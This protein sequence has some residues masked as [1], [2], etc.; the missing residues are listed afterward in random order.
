MR[1][2]RPL[3]LC[4]SALSLRRQSV[5][6]PYS[7]RSFHQQPNGPLVAFVVAA[8]LPRKSEDWHTDEGGTLLLG[9]SVRERTGSFK[10]AAVSASADRC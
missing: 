8:R 1:A 7:R 9:T 6:L 10:N 5:K 4:C 3:M 2:Q